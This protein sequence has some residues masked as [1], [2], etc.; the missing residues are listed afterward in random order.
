MLTNNGKESLKHFSREDING[1][2]VY[3][4]TDHCDGLLWKWKFTSCLIITIFQ[5]SYQKD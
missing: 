4:S 2:Q 3:E 5:N 1:Y